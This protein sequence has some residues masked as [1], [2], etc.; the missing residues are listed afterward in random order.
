[1]KSSFW[2]LKT[3]RSLMFVSAIAALLVPLVSS[4]KSEA[5]L[6]QAEAASA[7]IPANNVLLHFTAAP[8]LPLLSP[9][10]TPP[11][12]VIISEFRFRG[13]AGPNDEF[14]ELYNNTDAS[15]TV[16]TA[17]GSAGWAVASRNAAA[18]STM[19]LFVIPNGTIIPARGHYLGTNNSVNGYSLGLYPAGNGT[20]ATPDVTYP[21]GVDDNAGIALFNTAN[22]ANFSSSTR[23]DAIGFSGPTGAIADLYREGA[24][25]PPIGTLNGQYALLRRTTGFV[26]ADANDNAADLW[27]VS[28][29]AGTF[30]GS[31]PSSI[32]A[33]GP[34]NLSS[35][36]LR[37]SSL[38]ASL[39]DATLIATV[40]P[41]RV[42][43]LTPDAANNSTQGTILM[44]RRVTNTSGGAVT[45][46]RL[47][48]GNT[49]TYPPPAGGA[50]LR[51][52]S[53]GS[54]TVSNV[55][56]PLT[57]AATGTPAT[58]P[59]TVTVLGT[60]LEEP[61]TQSMGGGYNSTLT[62]ALPQPLAPGASVNVQF[63]LGVQ[64]GGN[65]SFQLNHLGLPSGSTPAAPSNLGASGI[66]ASQ[67]NLVWIDNSSDETG[68][69]IERKTGPGG[70]YAEIAT[71][72]ANVTS[73]NN[74][75]LSS[76]TLYYYRVRATNAVGDSAYSA[77]A[78]ATTFNMP[79]SVSLTAPSNNQSFTAP[80]NI[81]L[82]ASATDGDGTITK[83]QFFQGVTLLGEDTSAP[84]SFDWNSVG[85]GS[86]SLTAKAIDNAG[87]T[88]TSTAVP[89]TVNAP[90]TVSLTAPTN[91]Q[92]FT[93][94]ANITLTASAA[95]A[96]G[97][98]AK[99][100]FFQGTTLLNE[101]TGAPFSFNWN[102]VASGNYGLTAKAFDNSGAT[103]TSASVSITVNTLPTVSLTAPTNAQIFIAP[104]NITLSATA[105]D[106][107]GTISKV[108]FFQGSTLLNEDTSAP[109]SF[110]WNNVAAGGFSLTAKAFDNAGA[111]TTST[112]VPITVNAPPTVSLT[113]PSNGQ[114]FT[115]P[116]NITLTASA[117][118]ADGTI[119]K[120]QFFQGTTLLNEDTA[121]PY[122]FDWNNVAAGNYSLTAKAF[123]NA[124]AT[125][126]S[127]PIAIAI[128]ALPTV[129]LTAPSNGQLFT[130]PANITLT[131][132]ASDADGTISKV[133]FFQGASLLNE[134][135]SAPF[136]FDWNNV[137]AG[138]YSLTAKAFDNAGATTTS[139]T[140]PIT[141][142]AP[143]TVSLTAPTNGQV[144][145]AP[146]NITLT[147]SAADADGTIAKVQFFQGTTLLNEDSSAPFS[148]DW[149]NVAAGNYSL[150]AK[151]FDNAGATTSSAAVPITVNG[152]PTVSI[153]SPANDAVFAAGSNINI[154]AS[155]SDSDGAVTKVE[156]FKNGVLLGEDTTSPY[157][158]ACNNVSPGTYTLTTR[159]TD[160]LG[161]TETSAAVTINVLLPTGVARLD[162][163]NRTGGGGEDPLS[164]N[165]N[166]NLPLIGLPGR[167]G[168][169]LNLTLSY[170]SLVWTRNGSFISFD[171]D[172]G[173]PGPGFRL[174]FPVIQGPYVNS[175][176]GTN[177]FLLITPDGSRI[178]LRKVGATAFYEAGDSSHLLLDSDT[179]RLR[180]TD[181]TEL[182]YVLQGNNF[183]CIQIKDRNGNIVGISYT[184][185]NRI[186]TIVDTLGRTIKFNYNQT[187]NTLTSITQAWA[188]QSAPKVWASFSYSSQEIHT[189]FASS[190][191]NQGPANGTLLK[192]LRTVTLNTLARFDFDYTSWGQVTKINN[193]AADGHLLNYRSYNLPL[194]GSV[195]LD[196]CPR[197]TERRDWAENWNRTG[198]L[199]PSGLPSGPE[200]EVLTATWLQPADASWTL[201]DGTSQSG[202]VTQVTGVDGSFVKMY[203]ASEQSGAA[204]GWLRGLASMVETFAS[205][206]PGDPITKQKTVMNKWTQ[207]L[208]NVSYPL[209]PRI[210][211]TTVYEYNAAGQ[212]QNRSRRRTTY[213]SVDL[214]NG[215]TCHLPS[216]IV[217]YQSD[218]STVLRRAHFD[219]NADTAYI[220][221]RI[222]GL[223]SN[224]YLYEVDPVTQAESTMIKLS[225]A[226]D[227]PS[228]IEGND[229][230]VQHEAAYNSGFLVGRGNVSSVKRHDVIN[231]NQF[232]VTTT[233][234]N[235]AGSPVA[236][237]DPLSHQHTIGYADSF[238]DGIDR[239][240]FAYA[241]SFTDADGFTSTIKYD[242]NFGAV[243]RTQSPPPASQTVGAIK[244]FTYDDRLRVLKVSL[245][246]GTNTDYAHTEFEYSD[247]QTRMDIFETIQENRGEAHSFRIVDGHGRVIAIA[248]PHQGSSTGW[249]GQLTLFDKLGQAIKS[250]NPT[251]T[252]AVGTPT[253][254][255]AA[256][257]DPSW[258]YTQQTY[259]WKGRPLVTTNP[260]LTTRRAS[261]SGCGCAGGNTTTLTDE[262]TLDGGV[263][264]R[265]QLKVY[266]D[267][268]G[269]TV[270]T[271]LLNWENGSVDSTVVNTYNARDQ[272]T[273]VRA[274]A[275]PE[276]TGDSRDTINTYDGYGRL[277]TKHLPEY[278]PLLTTT[279]DYNDDDT[280]QK[281]TDPRGTTA[282][283]SYNSRRL[284]TDIVY[285]RPAGSNIPFAPSVT[286]G[287]DS[288]GNRTSMTDGFGTVTYGY[289]QLSRMTFETRVFSDPSNPG[290]NNVSRTLTYD[291][292]QGG[293]ITSIA[294]GFGGV[295]NYDFDVIGR[296]SSLTGTGY[297]V[298]QFINSMQYRAWNSLK[299]Q[300]NG[301]GYTESATYNA[302]LQLTGF[303]VRKPTNEVAMSSTNQYYDDG[304]LKFS[305]H[306]LERFDRAFTYDHAGRIK[307]ALT[308]S[309]ARD[310][311]S[312]T[313]GSAP[314]GAYRQTFQYNGFGE[315]TQEMDRLWSQ[316]A[317]TL[318]TFNNN[319]RD[320]WS[321]D[322][323]GRLL[324]GD[325]TFYTYDTAGRNTRQAAFRASTTIKYDGNGQVIGTILITGP[326]GHVLNI[327]KYFLRSTPMSGLEVVELNGNGGKIRS[328][329]YTGSRQIAEITASSVSWQHEDPVTGSKGESLSTGFFGRS[330]ELNAVGINVGLVE[331][332]PFDPEVSMPEPTLQGRNLFPAP[333]CSFSDPNCR[334]CYLD[335]IEHDC[336]QIVNLARAGALQIKLQ[337]D[338][339]ETRYVDVE[340]TLGMLYIR[341]GYRYT[342]GTRTGA[343]VPI[344]WDDPNSPEIWDPNAT[345][346]TT[347]TDLFQGVFFASVFGQT[348]NHAN[349]AL[350]R[351]ETA[352]DLAKRAATGLSN[353]PGLLEQIQKNTAAGIDLHIVACQAAKE[354]DYAKLSQ[355]P[356]AFK[357]G[358]EYVSG[359]VGGDGE[360]GLLQV[361]PLT[362]GVSASALKNV[363]TNVKAAT[364]Y[365]IGIKNHFNVDMRTALAVYNWGPGNFNKVGRDVNRIYSGSLSYADKILGC[366]NQLYLPSD[367]N[368]YKFLP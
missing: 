27:F 281:V 275:G 272:V 332:E 203:F 312:G 278:D 207:D 185:F 140:V 354:S 124:G 310:F 364:T 320:G 262:G 151:A 348:F 32:G 350:Q 114:L 13:A 77:E 161:A 346:P 93:A 229:T 24:G 33:P 331:P 118:D 206:T 285:G 137:A 126:T 67:I 294:D 202:K 225:F 152:R 96:D 34:E 127:S 76:S 102:N 367:G 330:E 292:N 345:V 100:Q 85:A 340:E 236:Q 135:T 159:A 200:V 306:L 19:T 136:S 325:G 89:I 230:P 73:Y 62:V 254:W 167:A 179:M 208:T 180:S 217:E 353:H 139:T 52:R 293:Q 148:F 351:T 216:D 237:S 146:A 55:N 182:Q 344:D 105:S 134:D 186:D 326:V 190:V 104:A 297:P 153:S 337:N 339:G 273:K 295:L 166:W 95:D 257:D 170:N 244:N 7:S 301:N 261:Y 51:L 233:K 318:S 97:A 220:S 279:Y 68:F 142:N 92:V 335:G 299:S 168:L 210:E 69:R 162:P 284:L 65:F 334:I 143:P 91:G 283:M 349:M 3:L 90:P 20:T 123:D 195:Q 48:V 141:V 248:S 2:S 99:V 144:F 308:G 122:N 263:A 12:G 243:T 189:N 228:S 333:N 212:V 88:T 214:G 286:F 215:M 245:E 191:T 39:L 56:D 8:M 329:A 109:Y 47:Q 74:T 147:A 38:P 356:L 309:E 172:D 357:N 17:D 41:N 264:R 343:M 108:Q 313:S 287:Y 176:V 131:A 342:H 260:D 258:L 54:T 49:T 43:D 107:D 317:T 128:N 223:I 160:N 199:G 106:T 120:V 288:I 324:S 252:N 60:T 103:T 336:G 226:Y 265:R 222:L 219:Y 169:D 132:T 251:E 174:G 365:L 269:R 267:V 14:I 280:V 79:P 80:A 70:T 253:Q 224:Q 6:Q 211:D 311:I 75:G 178:E 82:T 59:C 150:T 4:Q 50:D 155:A 63:L 276:G 213:Q 119:A 22:S 184:S 5:S 315:V 274:F 250:S 28:T 296:L 239:N 358:G 173:F 157:I 40:A 246:L 181:G 192:V 368:Q 84:F 130:A 319:R 307:E 327:K 45:K 338:R 314:T 231:S 322:K 57:C 36:V 113:A 149:N 256:G 129:S 268:L 158:F 221:R 53:I 30:G 352:A 359:V 234:Y 232:T 360:I 218:I 249:S 227:E 18:T 240:T 183:E 116:A 282:T 175:E 71:V 289:N 241:T 31:V 187:D 26:T 25:Y 323:T 21:L 298:S 86:Y 341:G 111:T 115:A 300:T 10:C 271:E 125:T 133:Q 266:A 304:S 145:T 204:A 98:I 121:A 235:T 87:A 194:D 259:D 110:D 154:N 255:T 277:K 42:R 165:Y 15:I 29:T 188:G 58:P 205:T 72:G 363:G 198:P 270:K 238:S 164:R 305:D 328:F 291:Y 366:A 83:V 361:K 94:P 23:L 9:T 66:S 46:L 321:Y 290:I 362:A 209:N 44:R 201:P 78:N 196:D 247:S 163:M 355:V 16:C 347:T 242:F 177:A 11:A 316:T 101:D 156:F 171:D 302:R 35:P 138:N 61:P 1:M 117:A 81:T 112:A 197:F 193:F 64:Q 37:N 303:E